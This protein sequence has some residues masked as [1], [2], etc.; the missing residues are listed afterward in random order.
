MT[1]NSV[2]SIGRSALVNLWAES[3]TVASTVEKISG[4]DLGSTRIA[5]IQ[6][7]DGSFLQVPIGVKGTHTARLVRELTNAIKGHQK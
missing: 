3:P 1:T 6:F 7:K 5:K 2:A 4:F